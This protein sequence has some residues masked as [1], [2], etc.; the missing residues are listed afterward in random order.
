MPFLQL[1][2][3]SQK[4]PFLVSFHTSVFDAERVFFGM[5]NVKGIGHIEEGIAANSDTLYFGVL[6]SWREKE[7]TARPNMTVWDM[8]I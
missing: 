6:Q 3:E 8:K 5:R 2:F 7:E 1:S 4:I